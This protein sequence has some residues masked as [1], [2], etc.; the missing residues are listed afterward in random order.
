MFELGER[1]HIYVAAFG[2]DFR[3][4]AE[5]FAEAFAVE[6]LF[7]LR[8]AA[9]HERLHLEVA[10]VDFVVNFR[11]EARESGEYFGAHLLG[12]FV[13]VAGAHQFDGDGFEVGLPGGD[14]L[15]GGEHVDERA[16]E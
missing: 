11:G 4:L 9:F 12:D 6:H 8:V 3:H 5:L 2:L 14:F 1:R 15:G 16:G 7:P 13:G 10:L